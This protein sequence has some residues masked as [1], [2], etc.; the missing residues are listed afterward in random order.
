MWSYMGA[1]TVPIFTSGAIAGTVKQAEARQQEALFSYQSAIQ[2]AF[3]DVDDAL[4]GEQQ[5]KQQLAATDK[6]VNALHQYASLSRALNEGGYTSYLEVLDAERSLFN[7]Q[8]TQSS[9]Q[10][11]RLI[12]VV[13]LYK[14]LGYGWPTE[15]PSVASRAKPEN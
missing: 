12:Q 13:N 3:A 2:S 6:Q 4:V 11:Q 14:A 5:T 7:A 10:G 1:A 15:N 9:L 8:L